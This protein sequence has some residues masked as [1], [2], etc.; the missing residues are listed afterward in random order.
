[1]YFQVAVNIPTLSGLFDYHV[2]AELEGSVQPGSLVVVPFGRQT[3]Q[4]VVVRPVDVPQVLA[5]KPIQAVL[6]PLP[7]LTPALLQLALDLSEQVLAPLALCIDLMLPPGLSVQADT[8]YHATGFEG[9]FVQVEGAAPPILTPLQKKILALLEERGDLRGRQFESAFPY[10]NWKA[11]AQALV[12]RGWLVSKPILPPP[13]VR[14]KVVRTVQLALPPAEAETRLAEISQPSTLERRRAILRFLEQEPWPV[15]VSWAYAAGGGN[16]ADLQRLAEVGIVILGEGEAWRDPLDH[17]QENLQTPPDLTPEQQLAWD[18]V[19]GQIAE[20]NRPGTPPDVLPILLHGVTGSGKTE[21]Y[22]RAVEETLKAGRQAVVLV[23]EISLTPQTVRRFIA[24]F[25]GQVGLVHSRLS[26]GERYDTWRRARLGLLKVIVGPRS[27]LFSPLPNLGLVVIDECHDQSYYQDDIAPS[28][29]VIQAARMLASLAGALLMLGS[30]TPDVSLAY[31]AKEE[32]WTIVR[33]PERIYAHRAAVA[34]HLEQLGQQLPQT[35]TSQVSASDTLRLPLPPVQLVDMRNELKEGNRSIFSRALQEAIKTTLAASQQAILFLNRRGMATYVFCRDCGHVLRC[36]RCDFP[37]TY[38][39][40]D[41]AL[42]CHTCNYRRLLPKK[43]PECGLLNIRQFGA[44]TEKVESDLH[45]LFPAARILRYDYETTRQKGAHDLLLSH[46]ANHHADIMIGTQMVAKGLDL[47]LVTLVGIVLADVGL[48][49]PDFNAGERAFQVLTQV[50]GRAGRSPLGGQ[51]ILQTF[52]PGHYA[53][54]AASSHDYGSFYRKELAYR[55]RIGYPPFSRLAR[56]EYRH[57]KED[58]AEAAARRMASQL[59]AWMENGGFSATEMIGP[60]P[61][62]FRKVAGLFRWQIVLRGPN[63][64]A[65]LRGR[66]L[67]NWRIEID[68]PSLL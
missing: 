20:V 36:P 9:T 53:I 18:T 41:G 19:R 49:L 40:D 39:L 35:N 52:Q 55:R 21:I 7:V 64:A 51:V 5:T 17:I 1:M 65:I 15:N 46:F 66:D 50:A 30:A 26:A 54:Q 63:V 10:V 24:R 37:L 48:T 33:L 61:C 11:A 32:K 59:L 38:H 47:P 58:E 14:P 13:T 43:C 56:L 60:V 6:D 25:P 42:I 34:A 8:L 22:L 2:P 12:A 45:G 4:G 57:A 44:G 68:P 62:F 23:P 29:S 28:Y 67:A 16:L 27:A 31:R 3:V